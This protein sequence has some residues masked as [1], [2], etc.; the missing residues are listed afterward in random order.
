MLGLSISPRRTLPSL[1]PQPAPIRI[2]SQLQVELEHASGSSSKPGATSKWATHSQSSLDSQP[3]GSNSPELSRLLGP[4]SSAN[5]D[6]PRHNTASKSFE[7][8]Q[9]SET[10]A[11]EVSSTLSAHLANVQN[12]L[13][14]A[15]GSRGS[16]TAHL[17][18]A[19]QIHSTLQRGLGTALVEVPR[20][21][22]LIRLVIRMTT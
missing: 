12:D 1:L 17:S 2:P 5:L 11:G 4:G 21:I 9:R 15:E 18:P 3:K 20:N 19:H 10:A 6:A 22:A 13:P 7:S 14:P 16:T 8:F